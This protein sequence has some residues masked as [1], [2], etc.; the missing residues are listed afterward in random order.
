MGSNGS[1]P[2]R[3]AT[4]TN[5]D[6]KLEESLRYVQ[7]HP[8]TGT[9]HNQQLISTQV[10]SIFAIDELHA[11]I[12]KLTR[13]IIALDRKNE[14]LEKSN[15]AL[16]KQMLFLTA[17]ATTIAVF[18]FL[19]VIG[20]LGVIAVLLSL[21]AGA[22]TFY[23]QRKYI[24]YVKKEME[25]LKSAKKDVACVRTVIQKLMEQERVDQRKK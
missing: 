14:K 4:L 22:L 13:T 20:L 8:T 23:I 5:M 15:L 2:C 16:Q 19:Q 18:G 7:S 21:V 25:F 9:P 3:S 17:V 24:G 6:K 10:E 12:G 1:K 11:G